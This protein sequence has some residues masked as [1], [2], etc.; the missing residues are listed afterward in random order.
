MQVNMDVIDGTLN[1]AQYEYVVLKPKQ[2][3]KQNQ[4]F[5]VLIQEIESQSDHRDLLGAAWAPLDNNKPSGEGFLFYST[6]DSGLAASLGVI[7]LV[8]LFMKEMP[9]ASRATRGS[10]RDR[11][12][13]S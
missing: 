3:S 10:G 6:K 13:T 4:S 12:G 8:G 1:N 5:D 9:A 7:G 2:I 11:A